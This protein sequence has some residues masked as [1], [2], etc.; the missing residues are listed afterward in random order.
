MTAPNPNDAFF[1]RLLAEAV[2]S[3]KFVPTAYYD[4]DGDCVEFLARP[5]PFYA[6]RVDDLVTVYYSQDTNEVVGSLIKGIGRFCQKAMKKIPGFKVEI[7]GGRVKLSHLFRAKL[8]TSEESIDTLPTLTY[9]ALI[10]VAEES[11]AET[12]FCLNER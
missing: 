9:Q 5:D 6:E 3:A 7:H 2:P 1:D 10:K 12:E 4:A 11:D 8:W